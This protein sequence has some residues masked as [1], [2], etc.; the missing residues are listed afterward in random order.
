MAKSLTK[1]KNTKQ[2]PIPPKPPIGNKYALGN[3]GGAPE[4]Y[5]EKWL[6]EESEKFRDWMQK[7]TSIYFKSFAIE[8]GYSPQR[9]SEF[10]NKSPEFAE[11]LEM[12]KLWQEQKLVNYGLFNKTNPNMTKFVLANC[13]RWSERS[14]L[15]GD[16]ANPLQFLLEKA[17]GSSKELI[18]DSE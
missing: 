11:A 5:T 14:T 2:K 16:A 10:A 9:F 4:I 6:R 8:R 13:H 1:I 3:N 18:D 15:A 12:A 17:D 7:E